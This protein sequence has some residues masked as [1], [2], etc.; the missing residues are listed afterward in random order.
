MV[1][2]E[3]QFMGLGMPL[4][5]FNNWRTRK[6]ES[7]VEI[8]ISHF[9]ASPNVCE[10]IWVDLETAVDPSLRVDDETNCPLHLLLALK[11]LKAYPADVV[12]GGFFG[13]K[14]RETVRKW[15]TQFV[16]KLA[17]L[18]QIKVRCL[19]LSCLFLT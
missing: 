7:N 17:G 13:I 10:R 14:S 4:A 2:N 18:L 3:E 8:F 16:N 5:G 1:V 15:R 11:Y 12:L 9:G 6:K 19:V